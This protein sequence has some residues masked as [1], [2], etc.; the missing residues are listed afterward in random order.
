MLRQ[1]SAILLLFRRPLEGIS[2]LPVRGIAKSLCYGYGFLTK[3]EPKGLSNKK[4]MNIGE[5][6]RKEERTEIF[7]MS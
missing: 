6:R 4:S 7:E 2:F 3:M 5:E 1:G